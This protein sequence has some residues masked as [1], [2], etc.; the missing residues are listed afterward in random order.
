[1]NFTVDGPSKLFT[2]MIIGVLTLFL[3]FMLVHSYLKE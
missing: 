3:V 2:L 1:M